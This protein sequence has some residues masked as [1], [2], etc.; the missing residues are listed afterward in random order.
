VFDGALKRVLAAGKAAGV[1]V[2]IYTGGVDQA[3]ARAA[4]GF[5]FVVVASDTALNRAEA[6]A[7]W[8]RY[9]G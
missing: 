4:E 8:G 9:R 1:P 6:K 2:G 3:K 5:R 7:A